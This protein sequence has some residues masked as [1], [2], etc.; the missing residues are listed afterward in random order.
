MVKHYNSISITYIASYGS[1]TKQTIYY[2]VDN[3]RSVAG[4]HIFKKYLPT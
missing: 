1:V 2:N 3:L 4:W